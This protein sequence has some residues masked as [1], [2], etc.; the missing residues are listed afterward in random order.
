MM[1]KNPP[2]TCQWHASTT[3]NINNEIGSNR[4]GTLTTPNT[5]SALTLKGYQSFQTTEKLFSEFSTLDDQAT[6]YF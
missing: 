2:S 3:K 5:K 4:N 1:P 6:N